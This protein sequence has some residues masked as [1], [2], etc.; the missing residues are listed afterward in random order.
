MSQRN[1]CNNTCQISEYKRKYSSQIDVP[2]SR[3]CKFILGLPN[4][5]SAIGALNELHRDLITI[6]AAIRCILYWHRLENNTATGPLLNEAFM[7]CKREGHTFY[8]NLKYT[9]QTNGMG[10]LLNT[11]YMFNKKAI[12]YKIK[13]NLTDQYWQQCNSRISNEKKFNTLT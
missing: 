7:E 2:H 10:Q 12:K 11:P 8:Q 4:S 6:K 1:L 9:L 3:Y 13:T 5:A